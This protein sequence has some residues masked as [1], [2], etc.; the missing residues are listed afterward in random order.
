MRILRRTAEDADAAGAPTMGLRPC[1][2]TP[3]PSRR[4]PAAG[5]AADAAA[6]NGATGGTDGACRPAAEVVAAR[7]AQVVT[8]A[9]A[10]SSI[11]A[12]TEAGDWYLSA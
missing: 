9:W 11:A 7:D 5:A 2:P 10:M 4:A 8:I 1:V 6:V 3:A 12:A